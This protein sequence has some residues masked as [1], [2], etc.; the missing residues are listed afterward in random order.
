M[1]EFKPTFRIIIMTPE[2][3]LYQKEVES[4]FFTGD[5]G[6]YEL[7]AYHYPLLGVLTE[8]NIIIDWQEAVAIKFGI[9]KF[10]ANSCVVLVEQ[11][12]RFR[13]QQVDETPKDIII[14]DET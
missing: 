12:D 11:K 9:V 7:L 14:D 13:P 2:E 6:E 4:A 8:G 3:L 5:K 10:F 1:E